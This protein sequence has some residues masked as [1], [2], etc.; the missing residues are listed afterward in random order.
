MTKIDWDRIK[1]GVDRERARM[2]WRPYGAPQI[3]SLE[4]S[5][6]HDAP[7]SVPWNIPEK[8]AVSVAI[9]GAFFRHPQNPNQPLTPEAIGDSANEVLE[10]GAST[11]HIHVRDDEGFNVLSFERFKQVIEPLKKKF[12]SLAVDGCLVPA[13]DG[14]WEIMKRVLESGLLDAAPVNAT[15]TY[16][17]DS[18]FAKPAPVLMEKTRLIVESGAVPEIAVY[19]DGD[20][21]NADRF[22]I[23]SGLI[24][25]PAVWLI[26][27][28][29]PGCS[30]MENPRQMI[31]GLTRSAAAIRDIDPDGVIM[32]CAAG[33]ASMYVATLAAVMGLH[34][35]IGM[36]D[37]YWLWPHRDDRIQSNR[38]TFE[39]ATQLAA[40]VGRPVA[41]QQEYRELIGAAPPENAASERAV[42]TGT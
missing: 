10:A 20:V 29:L 17:G 13:L 27:P 34:I 2:I 7:I 16:V 9:T 36:E 32:V 33:R 30:P 3:M 12:P 23:K 21:S 26:L 31:D 35:R 22:L 38:Q 40:V 42:A 18:L 8:L 24:K 14:E 6:L 15:A 1:S 41:T 25:T 5:A 37:T 19:T 4:A 28:A 39:L 11:V